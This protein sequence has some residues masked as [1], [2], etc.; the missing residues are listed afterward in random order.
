MSLKSFMEKNSNLFPSGFISPDGDFHY[1]DYMEHW[2]IADLLCHS[3]KY[4]TSK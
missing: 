3:Y 1:A 4:D 2:E